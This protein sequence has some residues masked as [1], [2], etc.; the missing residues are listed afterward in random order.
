MIS[1]KYLTMTLCVLASAV[2]SIVTCL[3]YLGYWDVFATTNAPTVGLT[4]EAIV[5]TTVL[6]SSACLQWMKS[7]VKLESEASILSTSPC[8]E[9]NLR[10]ILDTWISWDT[11]QDDV[12]NT[13]YTSVH[14]TSNCSRNMKWFETYVKHASKFHRASITA[15]LH[16]EHVNT[17]EKM[18]EF[19]DKLNLLS[20]T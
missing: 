6:P 20:G 2:C 15:S 8:Q 5:K 17:P 19:A 10:S 13:N 7:N 16:T 14:M 4:Q 1:H 3:L 9:E 12:D 11:L 18:Q